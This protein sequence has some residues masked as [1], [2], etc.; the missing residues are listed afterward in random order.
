[1]YESDVTCLV[2]LEWRNMPF[3]TRVRGSKKGGFVFYKLENILDLKF[4]GIEPR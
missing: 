2:P 4:V 1:M 3:A